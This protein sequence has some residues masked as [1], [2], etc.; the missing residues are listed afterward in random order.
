MK[1]RTTKRVNPFGVHTSTVK[2][3]D[4]TVWSKCLLRNSFQVVFWLRSGA[5]SIPCCF[6]ILAIVLCASTWP[7]LGQCSL[8]A[9]VGPASILLGHADDQCGNV[10]RGVR[11]FW[12]S[13]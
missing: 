1:K 2:K 4:A 9:A 12:R 11:P 6:R 13:E 7:R 3:S 8:D 5:G 10:R